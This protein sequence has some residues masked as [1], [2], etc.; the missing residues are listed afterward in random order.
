MPRIPLSTPFPH[1]HK[2]QPDKLEAPS[3]QVRISTLKNGVRVATKESVSP[4]AHVGVFVETGSR[5]ESLDNNGITHFI[6]QMAFKSTIHRTDFRLVR[7][8]SKLA[9]NLTC[10]AGREHLIYTGDVLRQ[11]VP[12][13][14]GTIQDVMKNHMYDMPEV[15]ATR[16]LNLAEIDERQKQ[17]ETIMM[18][19]IHE[20][21]YYANTLGLPLF[22][23]EQNLEKFTTEVL[24]AWADAS[25]VGPRVV[26]SGVGVQ[27]EEFVKWT[28]KMFSDLPATVVLEKKAAKYMGGDLRMHRTFPSSPDEKRLA[29]FSVAFQTASWHDKDLVPM[30]VLQLIMG[31]GGSF[32]SGG[33]GKGMFSRMYRNVL[34][35]HDWIE[36]ASSF[37]SIFTD[38]GLFGFYATAPPEQ[39]ESL[40]QIISKEAVNMTG[41]V[42]EV[43]LS[44]AKNQLK[45]SVFMQLESG[46]LQL[47][48]IGRQ[49]VTYGKV[50]STRELCEMIDAVQPADIQRVAESMLKTQPSVAAYGDLSALPRYDAVAKLLQ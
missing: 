47:E 21:A 1:P 43:E 18:E 46:P 3:D 22:P 28:D 48:D 49:V 6:E 36:T 8:M 41:S 4:I 45:T 50:H 19:A 24:G 32:S 44:R 7:E 13:V 20:A 10:S 2:L 12:Y 17:P 31:G 42:D 27:H 39:A 5:Y 9:A 25:F 14:L 23:P 40:V 16:D 33:P 37:N 38:S 29:H 11:Y 34:G 15:Q 30:C 26:V 35:Q